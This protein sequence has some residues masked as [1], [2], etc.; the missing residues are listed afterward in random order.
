MSEISHSCDGESMLFLYRQ[1]SLNVSPSREYLEGTLT[2]NEINTAQQYK[3]PSAFAH[4][5]FGRALARQAIAAIKKIPPMSLVFDLSSRGRP[6][7]ASPTSLNIDF[8][9]AHSGQWVGVMVAPFSIGLDLEPMD[10]NADIEG[11]ANAYFSREESQ[12]ML[13][14]KQ[15][16]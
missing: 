12:W 15:T 3:S 1:T 14:D 11:I 9:I 2:Q 10:R 6:F 13:S 7:I 8:N 16:V 4:Y 5:V